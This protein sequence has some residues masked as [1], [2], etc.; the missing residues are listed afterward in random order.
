MGAVEGHDK[1]QPLHT[2]IGRIDALLATTSKCPRRSG[3]TRPRPRFVQA[4][5]NVSLGSHFD[6]LQQSIKSRLHIEFSQGWRKDAIDTF[7]LQ[8]SGKVR[9][10]PARSVLVED[11]QD[12]LHKLFLDLVGEVTQATRRQKPRTKLASAFRQAGVEGLLEKPR[13]VHLA[14]GIKI[15]APFGYQ[16]GAF[17]LIQPMSLAGDPDK[18]LSKASPHMIEGSL[19]YRE[20][21]HGKRLVV[22]ADEAEDH[23]AGFVDML[24]SQMEQH[25]VRFFTLDA[26]DPLVADIRTNYAL[27]KSYLP[28]ALIQ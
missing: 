27:H 25:A 22:I 8:R 16:N 3:N 10:S 12:T 2:Y 24:R 19:L 21:M 14:N 5:F 7:I 9:L 4:A 20:T 23:D 26:I 15:D 11:P 17:N 28:Q 6:L 13:P 1:K 18:A